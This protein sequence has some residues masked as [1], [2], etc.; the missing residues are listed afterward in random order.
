MVSFAP[1][2]GQGTHT[3]SLPLVSPSQL[4]PKC[5]SP[6]DPW[7]TALVGSAI[8]FASLF[9]SL[10]SKFVCP[11]VVLFDIER[12]ST[13]IQSPFR[14]LKNMVFS[15]II[16][17]ALLM[18]SCVVRALSNQD[19]LGANL[20]TGTLFELNVLFYYYLTTEIPESQYAESTLSIPSECLPRPGTTK[21][22]WFAQTKNVPV[23]HF[24]NKD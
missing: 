10:V 19:F 5:S 14:N 1:H 20:C 11:E 17:A 7:V 24:S 2:V 3:L 22:Q 4:H 23:Q 8:A 13:V 12:S 16:A 21:A 15:C 6:P 9:K 18:L